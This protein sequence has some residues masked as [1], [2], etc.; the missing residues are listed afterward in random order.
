[1][2]K[3]EAIEYIE[4]C[5]L[6]E[7]E[8]DFDN[9]EEAQ[10]VIVDDEDVN[11]ILHL[12][13]G[14]DDD[15][16]EHGVTF[17]LIHMVESYYKIA[18][19]EATV[20]VFMQAVANEYSRAPE[21]MRTMNVRIL[22]SGDIRRCYIDAVNEASDEV[23]GVICDLMEDIEGDDNETLSEKASGFLAEIEW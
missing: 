5:R 12:C 16:E 18:G 14:F 10:S 21:W 20:K 4:Q 8:E 7:T 22:N 17:G 13:K 23:R 2:T 19:N 11:D 6:L 15:T 1:M 9:F 3:Q